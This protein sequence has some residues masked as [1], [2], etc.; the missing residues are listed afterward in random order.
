MSRSKPS[1]STLMPLSCTISRVRSNGKAVGVVQLEG[2]GR[3]QLGAGVARAP[4]GL[5]QDAHALR[6]RARE[7]RL[8]FGH[9]LEDRLARGEQRRIR[10]GHE[11]DDAVAEAREERLVE[12]D[13]DALLHGAAD[14]APQHVVA[15]LVAGQHAVHD[16]KG[17]AAGVLGHGAQ[18]A[19]HGLAR[20][21]GLARELFAQR[22]Q[23]PEGVGLVDR[24]DALVD[25]GDALEPHAGVDAL[26]GQR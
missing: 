14:D 24:R 6:Q 20:A 8:F 23:R 3:R 10:L 19:G 17:D 7:A 16:E 15:P 2:D 21:V 5:V 26:R 11:V 18:G 25:G 9:D 4:Q 22:D 1:S 13:R 12:A